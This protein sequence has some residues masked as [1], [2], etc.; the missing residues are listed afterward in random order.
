[1][2]QGEV[3]Y[4]CPILIEM[5]FRSYGLANLLQAGKRPHPGFRFPSC[6]AADVQDD[7]TDC[8]TRKPAVES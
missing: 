2:F 7:P 6:L 3:F 4:F 8:K 1:M 5:S